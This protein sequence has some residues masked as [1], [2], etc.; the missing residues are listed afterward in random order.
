MEIDGIQILAKNTLCR[1]ALDQL[2]RT[3][4]TRNGWTDRPVTEDQLRELRRCV[5]RAEVA[6]TMS[7]FSEVAA[8]FVVLNQDPSRN[9]RAFADVRYTLRDGKVIHRASDVARRDA[10]TLPTTPTAPEHR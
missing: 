7:D 5:A 1:A 8:D 6:E 4:R 9:V 10:A 3:A 2:F